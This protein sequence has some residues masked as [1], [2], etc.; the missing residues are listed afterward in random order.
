MED[1]SRKKPNTGPRTRAGPARTGEKDG[2]LRGATAQPT[3]WG[4]LPRPP[5]HASIGKGV[6]PLNDETSAVFLGNRSDGIDETG[7]TAFAHMAPT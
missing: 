2:R 6:R 1:F 7:Q 5:P 3:G 4:K